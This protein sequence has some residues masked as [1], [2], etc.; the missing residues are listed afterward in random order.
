MCL[1]SLVAATV[2]TSKSKLEFCTIRLRKKGEFSVKITQHTLYTVFLRTIHTQGDLTQIFPTIPNP[3]VLD[4]HMKMNPR[5]SLVLNDRKYSFSY[6]SLL[7]Q[8]CSSI[9]VMSYQEL[10]K[11]RSHENSGMQTTWITKNIF[12][13]S[14]KKRKVQLDHCRLKRLFPINCSKAH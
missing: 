9:S 1:I 4:I 7:S 13:G 11:L 6:A 14:K 2:E 5:L 3:I 12:I 10:C 8:D